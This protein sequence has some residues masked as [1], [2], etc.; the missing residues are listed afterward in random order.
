[1]KRLNMVALLALIGCPPTTDD[2]VTPEPSP[3][4]DVAETASFSLPGLKGTA[5]VVR[6]ESDV[7]HIYAENLEDL[8]LVEGFTMARDRYFQ[9]DLFRRQG[10]GTLSEVLG[11]DALEND[12]EAVHSGS[13]FTAERVLA[14][15]DDDPE[16]AAF[17]DAY[18]AGVNAYIEAVKAGDEQPPSEY[19]GAGLFLGATEPWDL[20]ADWDRQSVAS[21]AAMLVF[22]SSFETTDIGR[23]ASWD[24]VNGFFDGEAMADL[25][26][27]GL[28]DAFW[29]TEPIWEHASAP[30]FSADGASASRVPPSQPTLPTSMW[31]RVTKRAESV[32]ARQGHDHED[33]PWGSNAWAVN[34]S[35]TADGGALLAADGHL[36]LS[37]PPLTYQVH[38]D[39]Q[40]LGGGDRHEIGIGLAG[41]PMVLSGTNGRVAWSSTQLM[42]D[43]TDWFAE[44]IELDDDGKPVSS[45]FDGEW[46]DL[47]AHSD[48]FEIR[49]VPL[50][51]SVGRTEII[52]RWTTFDG[53]WLWSI[54]GVS[55][56]ADTEVAAG[57]TL[58]NM[59]GDWIIPQDTDADGKITALSYRYAG[60]DV[61]RLMGVLSSF[62]QAT[63][64]DNFAEGAADAVALSQNVIVADSGGSVFYTGYQAVPCRTHF[65][66]NPDGTWVEGADPMLIIDGTRYGAWSIPHAADGGVDTTGTGDQ[67]VI[68]FDRYPHAKD[69]DQGYVLTANND[70][71]GWSFDGS[72]TNDPE[73]IGGPWMMIR[74]NTIDNHLSSLVERGDVTVDDMATLQ[75]NHESPLGE[76]F[77]P[78]LLDAIDHARVI[79]V[80]AN[81]AEERMKAMYDANADRFDEAYNR[82]VAWGE[83]GFLA[84]SGVETFYHT[85]GDGD[86]AHA[87]AT[88]IYNAW[89]GRFEANTI[90]DEGFPSMYWP[91]GDTGRFRLLTW[92]LD[93]RGADNPLEQ[94]HWNPDTEESVF[95]DLRGTDEVETSDE[96]A[97]IALEGALDYLTADPTG[98]GK[99]GF[100]TDDMDEWIWGLRHHVR[101]VSM[102]EEALGG[103]DPLF[104]FL[105]DPLV[106]SPA[107]YPLAENLASDDPRADLPGFPRHGDQRGIDAA[108]PGT[109]GVNFD[110][111]SGPVFRMVISVGPQGPHGQNVIPG[112]QSGLGDSEF[113]ADQAMM[114]LAGEAMPLYTEVADVA[115]HATGRE[116]FTP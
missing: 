27:A 99:G 97:L 57:E 63:D 51:D 5:Y 25:R 2:A 107:L 41:L 12:I 7:P 39:T 40:H 73:Y 83:G 70:P 37:V 35:H 4:L 8:G 91:T 9:M 116:T 14:Q 115:A 96:V 56:S 69:P 75:G 102:L 53:R 22:F 92:M 36:G 94:S 111:D 74:A 112:G 67:C 89:Y 59:A 104:S 3:L 24:R 72:L 18:A 16:L 85:P 45:Y 47:V 38:L 23:Q 46:R 48:D 10:L 49:N 100:G 93:G 33:Q 30:G 65:P 19:E 113:Y 90:N 114:W 82:L 11:Q 98:D 21:V 31:D 76:L 28:V 29:R 88:T 106:I 32:E 108:D 34:G 42:G 101:F 54:E 71:G 105:T 44:E 62:G 20:M 13:R 60:L 64:V 110:F 68:P 79:D 58:V 81:D 95:F 17:A 43:I 66:R 15:L 80:P 109:S 61:A 84:K 103:P 52:D 1:M 55:A 78:V 87:V 26:N 6:T 50:L 77:S 86:A